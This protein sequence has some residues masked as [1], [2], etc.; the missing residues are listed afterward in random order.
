MQP[1]QKA[2]AES[3]EAQAALKRIQI[4]HPDIDIGALLKR[5][6]ALVQQSPHARYLDTVLECEQKILRGQPLPWEEGQAGWK[7]VKEGD[8]VLCGGCHKHT[9]PYWGPPYPPDE[10]LCEECME[11]I[12]QMKKDGEL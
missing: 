6:N 2:L 5:I 9:I 11:V 10:C 1:Y 12:S 3:M 8:P 4:H 7:E